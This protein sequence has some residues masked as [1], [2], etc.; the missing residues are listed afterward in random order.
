MKGGGKTCELRRVEGE[1]E[2]VE[3][4]GMSCGSATFWLEATRPKGEGGGGREEGENDLPPTM[5]TDTADACNHR[6]GGAGGGGGGSPLL[7]L[8]LLLLLPSCCCCFLSTTPAKPPPLP[9]TILLRGKKKGRKE[10]GWLVGW[11]EGK[12]EGRRGRR[13][14]VH[15]LRKREKKKKDY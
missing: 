7:L 2:D 13:D 12:K 14:C 11:L 15:T 3:E 1:E 4:E 8:L 6:S 5:H 10:G 9:T